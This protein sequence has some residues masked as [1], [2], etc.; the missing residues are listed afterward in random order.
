MNCREEQEQFEIWVQMIRRNGMEPYISES[1]DIAIQAYY[2][3]PGYRTL[4][5]IA[6]L[7]PQAAEFVLQD[8]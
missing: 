6:K 5:Y 2:T 4:E 8:T 1:F 3:N 7:N